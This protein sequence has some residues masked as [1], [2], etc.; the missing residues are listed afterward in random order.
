MAWVTSLSDKH[1]AMTLEQMLQFI[2]AK[3]AGK[4]LH[5]GDNML[6]MIWCPR[7]CIITS[8]RYVH[9]VT[10]RTRLACTHQCSQECP[11]NVEQ[12]SQELAAYGHTFEHSN[13]PNHFDNV[14]HSKDKRRQLG[15]LTSPQ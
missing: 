10:K 7:M 14:C 2:Q 4:A 8:L 9:S 1:Q 15:T 6:S 11:D 12:C 3:E 5:H 13:K